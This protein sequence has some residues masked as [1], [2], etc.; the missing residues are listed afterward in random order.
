MIT[1]LTGFSILNAQTVVFEDDFESYADGYNLV[2]AGYDVWKG[3]ATVSDVTIDGE[4]ANSGNKYA[5]CQPGEA[6]Y[7]FR[8][9]LIVEQG[10][11]YTF[12]VFTKSPEGK[13]HRPVVK[14]G[15]RI[16]QGDLLKL[17][18]WTKT[19]I[20]FT[21]EAGEDTLVMWIYSFPTTRV[22]VDDFR[23]LVAS[24]ATGTDATLSALSVDLGALTPAFDAGT[25][26]YTVELPN[27]TTATP[28]TTATLND[29][30]ASVLITDAADVTSATEADRTTTVLVT[31]ED[32]T[33]QITYSI[34]FNVATSLNNDATLSALA[35]DNGSLTPAFDAGTTAYTV[36]LASVTTATP[37]T[38][39]TLNDANASVVITDAAD[40]TSGTEADRT[41]S[42]VVTAEDGTTEKTYSIVFNV[43]AAAN[44]DATLSALSVDNGSLS[45]AFDAGTMAYTVILPVGTSA[46]PI[47]TATKNDPNASLTVTD[48]ANIS[49]ATE[50]DRT[51]TIVVTAED[52]TTEKTYTIVFN[53]AVSVSNLKSEVFEV[54]PNPATNDLFIKNAQNIESVKI[55]NLAGQEMSFEMTK[56]NQLVKMNISNLPSGLYLIKISDKL[57]ES[58]VGKVIKK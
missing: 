39:A 13:N 34:V 55:I 12:E 32:G 3:T 21:P 26:A 4:T 1:V 9:T 7:Y 22:D 29:A 14:V 53:L 57:N 40:V 43:A 35:V 38:T 48:A 50:A 33:T 45:P 11:N 2:D 42:I 10:K 54:Y 5:Q 23:L 58:Y 24:S 41:T 36:E 52:G 25:T 30:K 27:G 56:D 8:K 47:T 18:E 16:I 46:T 37:V 6:N 19:N 15:A 44:N 49:S 31:A 17:T 51:T 20:E 28:V